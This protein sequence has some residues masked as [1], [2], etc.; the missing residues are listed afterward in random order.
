MQ[1]SNEKYSNP[2]SEQLDRYKWVT[3][4]LFIIFVVFLA[5]VQI[6]F[7]LPTIDPAEYLGDYYLVYMI[8]LSILVASLIGF[9]F[10]AGYTTHLYIFKKNTDAQLEQLNTVIQSELDPDFKQK[11][12]EGINDIK[13][14]KKDP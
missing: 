11:L 5:M 4:W 7:D 2:F 14:E 3:F 12:L 9:C 1:K 6:Y 13:T 8:A 10:M